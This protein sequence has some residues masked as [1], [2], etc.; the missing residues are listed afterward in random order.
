MADIDV[1]VSQLKQRAE[2]A[3][4]AKMLAELKYQ[5]AKEAVEQATQTL[6][7]KYGVSSLEEAKELIQK[8]SLQVEE[9][10]QEAIAL[11]DR[12]EALN[13]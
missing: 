2:S 11:L 9:K 7:E 3:E 10:K 8:L 12:F 13:D 1:E 5:Q 6:K 4:R